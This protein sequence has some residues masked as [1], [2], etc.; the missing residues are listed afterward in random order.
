ML[1][2]INF[3]ASDSDVLGVAFVDDMLRGQH[4][5]IGM[6]RRHAAGSLRV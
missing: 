4:G 1:S 6:T 5:G 3:L 2:G